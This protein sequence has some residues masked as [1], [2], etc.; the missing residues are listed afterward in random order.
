[1]ELII[2]MCCT[3]VSVKDKTILLQFFRPF[4]LIKIKTHMISLSEDGET[5]F[6]PVF[7]TVIYKF[8]LSKPCAYSM[9]FSLKGTGSRDIINFL[10]QK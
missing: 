7:Y 5:F 9:S 8:L 1:M 3:S 6:T 4:D 10:I 2:A